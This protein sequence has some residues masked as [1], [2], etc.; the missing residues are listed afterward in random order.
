MP[1]FRPAALAAALCASSVWAGTTGFYRQPA[2]QGG[3]VYLV[4]EGDLWRV[5][6]QGG[7]AQRLTTHNG[8]ESQP[9][10]SPDGQ[11]LAFTGQYDGG[12]EIYLMPVAGGVPKR[13]TWEGGGMRVWGF[14]AAGEIL[15]TGLDSRPGSQLFAI[16]V[17]TG[18]RRQLPVGQA[19]DAA[20]SA[21]GR[22]LYFTRS[23]LRSDNARQ[24]RGGAIARLWV[25][26][27]ME[28]TEARPLI[29]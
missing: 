19:S 7:E 12:T 2:L 14:T 22:T 13:L 25:M 15:Y 28:K 5:G 4:A 16:D 26:D 3:T 27:L 21:D 10:V 20:L 8:Q 24:Y 29:A 17:K 18:Q 9:A 6:A 11:W 1:R 23:G